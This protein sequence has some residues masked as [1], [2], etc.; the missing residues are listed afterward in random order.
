MSSSTPYHHVIQF[1]LIPCFPPR[2]VVTHPLHKHV[3][4]PE[5][6]N[7]VIHNGRLNISIPSIPGTRPSRTMVYLAILFFDES[8]TSP[9]RMNSTS[10]K[11]ARCRLPLAPDSLM[12]LGCFIPPAS[13]T[14]NTFPF[15]Q[16][17]LAVC[18]LPNGGS[19]AVEDDTN[20]LCRLHGVPG[21]EPVTVPPRVSYSN[22]DRMDVLETM[23]V[24]S[25]ASNLSSLP[26]VRICLRGREFIRF[27]EN[28]HRPRC[29]LTDRKRIG[30]LAST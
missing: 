17:Y 13:I 7:I 22:G 26:T 15:I 24:A 4:L 25:K 20:S 5:A 16:D 19:F 8:E 11:S 6:R 1:E 29:A 28:Y 21:E 9:T 30:Y 27:S 14:L 12:S 18:L 3:S 10:F 23:R 2:S